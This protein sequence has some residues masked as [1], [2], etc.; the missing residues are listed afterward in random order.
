[1]T[2]KYE[3]DEPLGYGDNPFRDN[4]DRFLVDQIIRAYGWKI[5]GRPPA[6]REPVWTDGH[7]SLPQSSVVILIDD[8]RLKDLRDAYLK[9]RKKEQQRRQNQSQQQRRRAG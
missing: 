3:S 4:T 1:M 9:M 5:K 8:S 2:K 6:P 7:C